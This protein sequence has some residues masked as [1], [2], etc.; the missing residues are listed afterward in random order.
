MSN[1]NIRILE[2]P[3]EMTAVE[4]LQRQVW[5]GSETDV[6]PAHVFIAA[7]HNGG[8]VTGAYIDEQLIGFVFGFPG[9]EKTPDGKSFFLVKNSWGDIGPE[10]GYINV[11]E[12]YFAINTVSLIIPKAAISKEL[13]AKLG[14]R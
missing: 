4:E 7:V 10:H 3:E 8:I 12:A 9:I 2:T 1:F 5:H 11:S 14:I 6:V 13:L